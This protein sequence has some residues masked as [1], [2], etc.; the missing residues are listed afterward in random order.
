MYHLRAQRVILRKI[1][2]IEQVQFNVHKTFQMFY[3]LT[4]I[5]IS[6]K[7]QVKGILTIAEKKQKKDKSRANNKT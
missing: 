1:S 6:V 4:A 7:K 2:L 3:V 5:E